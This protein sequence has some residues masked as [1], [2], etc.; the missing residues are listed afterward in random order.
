MNPSA[1]GRAHGSAFGVAL[2]CDFELAGLVGGGAP[3]GS[4]PLGVALESG[5]RLRE[6]FEGRELKRLAERRN[7]DRSLVSAIDCDARGYRF[8]APGFAT[9]AMATD[10]RLIECTPKAAEAWR[11]QRYL[12]AQVLPFASAVRGFEVLHA[13]AVELDGKAIAFVGPGGSGKS[14]LALRLS[15]AGAGLLTDDVLAIDGHGEGLVAH[16]AVAQVKVRPAAAVPVPA[17]AVELGTEPDARLYALPVLAGPTQLDR[18]CLLH[19]GSV[20]RPRLRPVTGPS[21]TRLLASTFN[22]VLATPER[23]RNQ[24]QVCSRISR[25]VEVSE[26]ELPSRLDDGHALELMTVLADRPASRRFGPAKLAASAG[27]D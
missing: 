3:A 21:A 20:D 19:V 16:P 17:G 22:F 24:L 12:A 18:L 8:H 4:E 27:R 9:C 15:A 7:A 11:W 6:R 1:A 10:A 2:E 25:E 13:S 14:T 26:L 5:D 23:L